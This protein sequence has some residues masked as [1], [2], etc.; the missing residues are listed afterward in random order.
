[1]RIHT[2]T[3]MPVTYNHLLCVHFVF[4]FAISCIFTRLHIRHKMPLFTARQLN[5][6]EPILGFSLL[7]HVSHSSYMRSRWVNI[8]IVSVTQGWPKKMAGDFRKPSRKRLKRRFRMHV[9]R[10]SKFGVWILC[11]KRQSDAFLWHFAWFK[12]RLMCLEAFT[13]LYFIR[14]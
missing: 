12:W 3:H 11:A 5:L 13:K 7:I 10:I 8:T 9:A 14:K 4:I 6:F 2:N 1:M